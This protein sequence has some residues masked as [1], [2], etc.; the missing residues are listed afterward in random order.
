MKKS[1]NQKRIDINALK[2]I[3]K[4]NL[5]SIYGGTAAPEVWTSFFNDLDNSSGM[6]SS[7]W[8]DTDIPQK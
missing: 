1:Q 3:D 5:N 6:F 4:K 7:L 2:V 8:G